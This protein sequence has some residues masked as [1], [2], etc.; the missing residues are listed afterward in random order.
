MSR[1]G[2]LP[3]ALESG[4]KLDVAVTEAVVQGPKGKLTVPIPAGVSIKVEESNAI[5][6][7]K[8]DSKTQRA[9]HGLTRAL[10]ANAVLGV[11]KGFTKKLEIHGVGYRAA[12]KGKV[13]NFS[14]GY[15]HP[16]D[17]PI[18]E[19]IEVKIEKNTLL[20]ISGF[21]K[22]QVGQVAAEMR[23]LRP[24]DVY[25]LKGVRYADEQLRKKAGKTGA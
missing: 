7:R 17:F 12:V 1:I 3:V 2:K 24:P 4:V 21:D 10:L 8:D 25:K 14:L 23:A 18:P 5:V 13:V 16:V 22:Q 6:E 15:T 19:G 9:L 20:E 11:T